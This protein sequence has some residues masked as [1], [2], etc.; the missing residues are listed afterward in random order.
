MKLSLLI[1][2]IFAVFLSSCA[3]NP[4]QQHAQKATMVAAAV[5][6]K[7]DNAYYTIRKICIDGIWYITHGEHIIEQHDTT[8]KPKECEVIKVR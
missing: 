8:G 2:S 7:I 1:V 4:D 5:E 3:K 6:V